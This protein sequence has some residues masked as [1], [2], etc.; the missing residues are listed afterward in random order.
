MIPFHRV[1][2][3]CGLGEAAS[4][5]GVCAPITT[6]KQSKKAATEATVSAQGV[7]DH[8]GWAEAGTSDRENFLRT[9][10]SFLVA[11]ISTNCV[12]HHSSEHDVRRDTNVANRWLWR[13]Y[14]NNL[15]QDMSRRGILCSRL[16]R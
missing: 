11:W 8:F 16:A 12:P 4:G 3:A 6:D 1:G 9:L 13:K 14:L 2:A 7:K 15:L 10:F 5:E